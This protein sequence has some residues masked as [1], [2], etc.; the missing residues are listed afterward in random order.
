MSGDEKTES[1][2]AAGSLGGLV[3]SVVALFAAV[4]LGGSEALA[5]GETRE[6]DQKVTA[7]DASA[8]AR[9]GMSVAVDRYTGVV[10]APTPT[11]DR[12][13]TV[14]VYNN[15][16]GGWHET[17][18]LT[19]AESQTDGRFG[20]SVDIA[21]T[22]MVVGAPR[23]DHGGVTNAGAV[24]VYRRTDG[25]WIQ[26]R[27]LTASDADQ[28]DEFGW[29][30]AVDGEAVVVGAPRDRH[31]SRQ[32]AGSAYVFGREGSEWVEREKLTASDAAANSEFGYA[33]AVDGG[34]VL[35]GAPGGHFSPPEQV[36]SAHLFERDG[37]DW[38]AV[39]RLTG[40][41]TTDRNR[42]G[43][44]VALQGETAV[45]GAATYGL[46]GAAG[47]VFVYGRDGGAWEQQQMLTAPD[48][49]PEE[50]GRGLAF[51][52]RRMIVGAP[53][54]GSEG[55]GRSYVYTP[56]GDGWSLLYEFVAPDAAEGDRFGVAA[57]LSEETFLVGAPRDDHGGEAEAGSVY[58]SYLPS[59]SDGD[60]IP[61]EDDNC[62]S[63]PN[64]DQEDADD[65]GLGDACD[66]CAHDQNKGSP[67]V[68]GCGEPD[69]DRDGDG[70]V[71]CA[72]EGGDDAG[73]GGD[74][75]FVDASDDLGAGGGDGDVGVGPDVGV[76]SDG[77]SEADAGFE[78]DG[79]EPPEA[80]CACRAAD[81]RPGA[82]LAVF[83]FFIVALG[84]RARGAG[85][86]PTAGEHS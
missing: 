41:G 22:R 28:N 49:G 81:G 47:R 11:S 62:P 66:E 64:P 14:S 7:S 36:S 23:E 19:G 34:R 55:G 21:G 26:R 4:G 33:V 24:Y 51:D 59:D 20:W 70:E 10:G 75:G 84:M 46:G 44:R 78:F 71:E 56:E 79:R 52:Q 5:A 3:A 58:G 60:T 37:E 32:N 38:R 35:V 8:D 80:G 39:K 82:P 74:G 30:V 68:C 76:E 53:R 57:G 45:V 69:E 27:K 42:F 2:T 67:G 85:P 13:G 50:F 40:D 12:E 83:A 6:V 43:G 63:T 29:S 25:V 48:G 31:G 15:F 86:G 54:D 9:F 18:V 77:G 16:D 61:D 65:D 72:A 1:M 17:K 73:L